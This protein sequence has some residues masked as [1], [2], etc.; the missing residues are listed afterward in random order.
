MDSQTGKR[1]V[2]SPQNILLSKEKGR[3][4]FQKKAIEMVLKKTTMNFSMRRQIR[5][6]ILTEMDN[7]ILRN[8]KC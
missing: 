3:Q 1:T 5:K 6:K 2:P 8:I 4:K 7:F